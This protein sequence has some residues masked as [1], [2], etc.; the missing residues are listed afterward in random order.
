[1]PETKRKCRLYSTDYLKYGFTPLQGPTD[2]PNLRES[3]LKWGIELSRSLE[4]LS[5]LHLEKANK[6]VSYF[7]AL[8]DKRLS[9][10]S[11][12]ELFA[13]TSKGGDDGFART[14]LTLSRC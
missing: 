8:R 14:R 5:S 7:Q 13:S 2:V 4:N 10:S 6:D 12:G 3:T 9:Q 1:M 11:S